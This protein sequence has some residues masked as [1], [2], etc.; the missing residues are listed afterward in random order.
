M[1]NRS[2]ALHVRCAV[3]MCQG[4]IKLW[5]DGVLL[6]QAGYGL[7][8][9]GT[10]TFDVSLTNQAMSLIAAAPGHVLQSNQFVLVNGGLKVRRGIRLVG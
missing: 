6:G 2:V 5:H 3:A 1:S 7:S 9:G 10:G 8:A 4:T